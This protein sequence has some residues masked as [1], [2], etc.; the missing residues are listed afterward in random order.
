[1]SQKNKQKKV[2]TESVDQTEATNCQ[3]NAETNNTD[4]NC[5][6]GEESCG[7]DDK[8]MGS[9]I[10]SLKNEN[11]ELRTKMS[12]INDKYLRLFAEFDNYRKRT[13]T[14]K[15]EIIK[16]GSERVIKSMLPIVD[17]FER[18]ISAIKETDQGS[19]LEGVELIYHKFMK[20]LE[21]DG[22]KQMDCVGQPFDTDLHEAIT[23]IPVEDKEMKG[24]V[25]DVLEKGYTLND[26]VIRFAKVIIGN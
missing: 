4:C 11:I 17:D 1:M 22:L 7:C 21:K 25:M 2:E 18:A 12:D 10:D 14:E 13:A 19:V 9:E 26:K 23:S 24:K 15:T 6:Q 8:V 5:Q 3:C 20:T 16:N